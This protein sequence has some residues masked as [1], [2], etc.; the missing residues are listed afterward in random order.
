MQYMLYV[1]AV[2]QHVHCS[3]YMQYMLYVHEVH[4]VRTCSTYVA[5]RLGFGL[6]STFSDCPKSRCVHIFRFINILFFWHS[7]PVFARASRYHHECSAACKFKESDHALR[8]YAKVVHSP[9]IL[10]MLFGWDRE[11]DVVRNP[12]GMRGADAQILTE[13]PKRVLY[14]SPCGLVISNEK[15]LQDYLQKVESVLHISLFTFR[16]NVDLTRRFMIQK[17]KVRSS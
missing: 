17:S 16:P 14:F 15:K 7:Y 8:S 10:P 5:F 3:T 11:V 2:V 9:L 13:T 1:H 6:N 4:A 12:R